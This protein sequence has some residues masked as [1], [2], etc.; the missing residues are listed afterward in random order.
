MKLLYRLQ[1]LPRDT[2]D[3]LFLLGVIAWIILPQTEH[4]P[5]WCSAMSALVL[6]WR[7]WIA[8][9]G[10]PLPSRWW[11][12]LL[13]L[14]ASGATFY[15]HQTL[16]GRD[17]GVTF[18]VVLLALKTLEMRAR[19]DAFVVFFLGFFALLSNFFFSQSLLTAA[20]MVVGLMG[21]LTALVNQHM[22]V[23]RPPLL[24]AARTAGWMAL[25]GAPIMVV[26]FVLFPRIAPLWGLP[27][28]AMG[29]RTGLSGKMQVGTIASLALDSSVAMRIR[30]EGPVPAQRDLYFRGPVLTTFDG[31][32]WKPLRS[33]FPA[34]LQ[35]GSQLQVSGDPIRYEVTLEG[36]N[37]P[38]LP[39]LDA[40]PERPQL[41][42]Y[43]IRM[44]PELQWMADRPIGELVRFKAQSYT[45]FRHGPLK[46]ELGLQDSVDLPAGYNPRTLQLALELRRDPRY[47]R[48]DAATLVNAVMDKLRTGGYRYTLEPGVYGSNTADEFWFDRKEGFCEHIASSFVLLLRALDVPARVVTGYQGGELNTLD[49]YWTVRQSD[50]HAWTEVWMAGQGW[51]RVDPTSAVAPARTGSLQRLL[52]PR[53]AIAQ[54]LGAMSPGFEIN[55]RA[56]WEATNNR[57]NQWVLNYSQAKQLNL[58]RN[59]GFDSPGWEDLSTLLIGL[60]V[61]VS[62]VGAAWAQWERMRQDPWLRL[63]HGA[64]RKLHKAG[65]SLPPNTPPRQMARALQ[66]RLDPLAPAGQA[67]SGSGNTRELQRIQDWLLRLEAWRYAAAT[68]DSAKPRAA[69]GTLRREFRQ[70]HWPQQLQP[71]R[72]RP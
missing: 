61:A 60:I 68:P 6:L 3:T 4:L 22:P 13:L 20:A 51:V 42:G 53:S 56:F 26:L 52:P 15:S 49:G 2:R 50:A 62:L 7:G 69:L 1:H 59:I 63:L 19:R 10:K 37:R 12:L 45:T 54:A 47:A 11:L 43:N 8:V 33:A 55:L 25:L 58:L 38:W 44:F 65:L 48:A 27:G 40:T 70:L 46:Q 23:G 32:E 5:L 17:A 29:G 72:P 16:M 66:E 28:D 14:L 21:L 18:V 24:L 34:Q 9:Q 41:R 57:W 31:R 35:L 71:S 39:V 36:N 67:P 64:Q 30:F